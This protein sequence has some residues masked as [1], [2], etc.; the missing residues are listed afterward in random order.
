[1]IFH[2]EPAAGPLC[3]RVRVPGDKSISHRAVLFAA[4]AEGTSRLTGVLDSADVRSTL[5]AVAAL[6][7]AVEVIVERPEGL[8]LS[9]DGWGARGPRPPAGPIDCGNSGTTCRLLMG[10]LAPWPVR[11]TLTGDAS[12]S[13]RP[14]KRVTD[15]L[16]AMGATFETTEGHLPVTVSG[17]PLRALHYE[18]PVASAQVKTAVLLAGLF[19][20]GVTTV[21]EPAP[22]RDHTER[23]LPAFG[24]GVG[25]DA[26][27]GT[28]WVDG[29]GQMR[30]SD[31]AVP[32]DPSSAAFLV[33]AAVI[34]PDSEVSLP[35]VALN[36]T[37]SGFVRVL[38]RMGAGVSVTVA[39]AT[40]AEPAGTITARSGPTLRPTVVPAFE[41]PSLIDEMPL[42]AVVAT[43][44]IGVTRFEGVGEL[45]VKESDRLAAIVDGLTALGA[46]A[47]ATGDTLEVEGPAA[48]HGARLSSLGD[49]RLAMAWAVAGLI[50]S[51]PVEIDAWEAVDVSYPHFARDVALLSGDHTC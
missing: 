7:A 30:A 15:P 14:M 9:V 23:L 29:S 33:G 39:H 25:R 35:D 1:M 26:E 45:R 32:A 22:S 36:P 17:A 16:T 3:G 40:G 5:A 8:D 42:L 21:V 4:M 12:L 13:R 19:A 34:V 24:I 31:V 41:A 6:G 43:Q 10:V 51:S 48:L 37:R 44:A 11:V 28:C 27:A 18:M 38:Q 20:R 46:R 49:H 2:A 50:A 47:R